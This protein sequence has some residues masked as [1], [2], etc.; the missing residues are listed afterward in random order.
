MRRKSLVS[1][2]RLIRLS[3]PVSV[4]GADR[5]QRDRRFSQ[6]RHRS[7]NGEVR[8]VAFF[9]L[10]LGL[11][12]LY[13]RQ[14]E[15]AGTLGLVGFLLAFLGTML[16]AG[17]LWFEAF[18]VPY[19]AEVSPRLA[20]TSPT[21]LLLAGA[22]ASFASFG[23]GWLLFGIASFRARVFPRVAAVLIILGALVGFPSPL[24]PPKLVVLA[25]AV[26]WMGF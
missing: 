21:G 26:G 12:G 3:G 4:G 13:A 8:V 19:L 25:L 2:A 20:E 1:L 10:L 7:I 16:I 23:V 9:L 5:G 14:S 22:A 17:D 15:E 24:F 6:R 11:V 18:A